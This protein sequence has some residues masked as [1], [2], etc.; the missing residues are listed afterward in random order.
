M[1]QSGCRIEGEVNDST[2]LQGVVVKNGAIVDGCLV[3]QGAIISEEAHLQNVIV[4]HGAN[5]PSGHI[6]T[7]G[8][9]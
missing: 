4:D 9:F 3:G 6:Q 7:G 2:L 1:I 8:V 5:V